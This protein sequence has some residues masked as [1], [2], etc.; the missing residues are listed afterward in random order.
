MQPA[1]EWL[2][3]I[4]RGESYRPRTMRLQNIIVQAGG[5]G[6]RLEALTLNTPKCLVPVDNLPILF[7]SF[8]RFPTS[9]FIIIADYKSDVLIKYL[10]AF[11]TVDFEVVVTKETGT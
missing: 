2:I 7:H 4:L 6:R 8:K 11:A 3:E 9:R 10:K 5:K 1:R